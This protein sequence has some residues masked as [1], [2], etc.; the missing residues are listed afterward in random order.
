MEATRKKK[1]LIIITKSNWGGA[2]RY[3]FDVACGL[4]DR[5]DISV[6]YGGGGA[7]ADMLALEGIRAIPIPSLGR[8]V[9]P[10]L[11]IISF[12]K[13]ASLLRRERPDILHLNS[14]KVGGIGA[15]AGRLAKIPRI[16]FSAHGW[17]WNEDRGALSRGLIRLAYSATALFSH[18]IIAVSE[19]IRKQ[20]LSLPFAKD[21]MIVIRHG[22]RQEIL[23]DRGEARDKLPAGARQAKFVFG[24]VAELHPIKGLS[25]AIEAFADP[26]L[27]DAAY[28][29]WGEGQDRKRLEALVARLGLSNRVFLPG[30]MPRAGL[31]MKAFDCFLLPS[32]SEALGYVLLEAGS[33]GIPAIATSVGGI[34]EIITDMESGALVH[35]KSAREISRAAR[36]MLD[37]PDKR[38]AL[39]KSLNEAVK[40]R[41]SLSAMLDST[42]KSYES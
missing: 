1:V 3:V 11:D 28:V 20:G 12:V 27:A 13:I 24:T 18:E 9:N 36:F 37:N 21:K 8:D 2:Q 19:A 34:P 16:V 10:L 38:L 40:T 25:Y 29:I 33:A 14:S 39:G 4:R 15:L 23:T 32:L 30:A 22:I 35:P 5:F 26:S 6:A 42:A 7:L 31:L 41:F 17:A